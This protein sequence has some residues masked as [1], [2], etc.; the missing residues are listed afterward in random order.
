MVGECLLSVSFRVK[1][2]LKILCEY[3]LEHIYFFILV[4]EMLESYFHSEVL[5]LKRH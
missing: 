3:F 4:T 1:Y 2:I 5:Q